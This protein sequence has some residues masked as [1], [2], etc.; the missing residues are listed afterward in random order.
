MKKRLLATIFTCLMAGITYAEVLFFDPSYFKQPFEPC[1]DPKLFDVLYYKPETLEVYDVPEEATPYL[2]VNQAFTTVNNGS[3]GE[4]RYS[5]FRQNINVKASDV[6]N[7]KLEQFS[8]EVLRIIVGNGKMPKL[9][10]CDADKRIN[11]SMVFKTFNG[12]KA[13]CAFIK[14]ADSEF[15]KGY[16]Y[17]YVEFMYKITQGLCVRTF[18]GNDLDFFGMDKKLNIRPDSDFA[19][20]YNSFVFMDR[21][22]K[23]Y[24]FPGRE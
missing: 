16:K 10:E 7:E 14:K 21:D 22:K 20:N 2:H 11:D 6:M 24:I 9:L 4:I 13:Y 19:K 3:A 1:F 23:G 15:S 12:T 17:V 18:L 5:L 8:R